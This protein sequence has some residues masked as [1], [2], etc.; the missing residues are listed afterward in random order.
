MGTY[1]WADV[2]FAIDGPSGSI[3]CGGADASGIAKDGLSV[4][5]SEDK[6]SLT[7]GLDGGYM[8]NLHVAAPGTI[9]LRCL[10]TSIL[11]A[12]LNAMYK[13]DTASSATYGK[14]KISIRDVVRGDDIEATGAGFRK[15]PDN[16]FGEDG[17]IMEW[18]FNCGLINQT[19]GTG[20]AQI[21]GISR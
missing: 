13:G 4:S 9:T 17:G 19:L 8:H 18:V 10:K 20:D 21:T 6:G 3:S 7:T 1:S 2:L 12:R 14:N 16:S 11:N 5:M 15:L